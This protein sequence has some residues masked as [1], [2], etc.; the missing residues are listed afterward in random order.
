MFPPVPGLR[1]CPPTS[2]ASPPRPRT[3]K[4]AGGEVTVEGGPYRSPPCRLPS[5]QLQQLCRTLSKVSDHH[6]NLLALVQFFLDVTSRS[7]WVP[8]HPCLLPLILIPSPETRWGVGIQNPPHQPQQTSPS[9]PISKTQE[10]ELKIQL[11][12]E[13]IT[14]RQKA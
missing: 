10:K 12:N 4:Q 8:L 7:R 2:L 1:D 9:C 3:S 13:F 5:P 6:H 11:T 14:K